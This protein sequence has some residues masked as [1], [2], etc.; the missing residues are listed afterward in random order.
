MR[1]SVS[2]SW[3]TL[4]DGVSYRVVMCSLTEPDSWLA[5]NTIPPLLNTDAEMRPHSPPPKWTATASSGSS[6]VKDKVTGGTWTSR[7][8]N[9]V[10]TSETISKLSQFKSSV[11][12]GANW[13]K[14]NDWGQSDNRNLQP[15]VCRET[16]RRK[17][18]VAKHK[19]NCDDQKTNSFLS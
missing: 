8:L 5:P 12:C 18:V 19:E 3:R 15:T 1:E 11:S 16:Q 9:Q 7:Q 10:V 2:F 6:T 14:R 4:L 13:F 17:Y